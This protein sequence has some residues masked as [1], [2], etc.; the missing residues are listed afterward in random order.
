MCEYIEVS[1]IKDDGLID[2]GFSF[3]F[4]L[5]LQFVLAVEFLYSFV[6][7]VGGLLECNLLGKGGRL[8][9]FEE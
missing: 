3:E 1:S 2:E 6:L 5:D 4:K 9:L 7:V 8:R